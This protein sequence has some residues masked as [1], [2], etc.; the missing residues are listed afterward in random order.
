MDLLN[1]VKQEMNSTEIEHMEVKKEEYPLE[2]EP[3]QY[4]LSIKSEMDNY[5]NS[6]SHNGM[7]EDTI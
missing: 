1:Q 4:Q 2:T 3:W 6:R 5:N 7:W